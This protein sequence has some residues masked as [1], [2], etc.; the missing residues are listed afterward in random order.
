MLALE[1]I[2]QCNFKCFF[3]GVANVKEPYEIITLKQ[4]QKMVPDI[5]ELGI[6]YIKLS[7]TRG[8]MFIHPEVYDILKTFTDISSVKEIFFHTNFESVNFDKLM[9]SGIDTKKLKIRVSH[10]GAAGVEQFIQQTQKTEVEYLNVENNIKH[11][12]ELGLDLK[13][14]A[15]TMDYNYDIPGSTTFTYDVPNGVCNNQWVPRITTQGKFSYCTCAPVDSYEITEDYIIGDINER[16]LKDLYHDGKRYE[17]W[18]RQKEGDMP[19]ICKNCTTF[20]QFHGTPSLSVMKNFA[21]C[22]KNHESVE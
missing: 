5:K 4:I 19:D 21:V 18:K 22:K 7:P 13:C 17:L 6:S 1:I 16:S 9:N 11:A 2:N 3:C 8:E 12:L 10:Y 15:R 20:N 14:D